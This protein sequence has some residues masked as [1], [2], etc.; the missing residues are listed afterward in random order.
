MTL[1]QALPSGCRHPAAVAVECQEIAKRVDL[2]CHS[3]Y[4]TGKPTLP[5]LG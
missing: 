3:M 2:A 4:G 1:T 5:V